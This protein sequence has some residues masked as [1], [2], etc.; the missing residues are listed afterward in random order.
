MLK[1]ICVLDIA[2]LLKYKFDT[3]F[4][5]TNKLHVSVSVLL[6]SIFNNSKKVLYLE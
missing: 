6:K 5:K 3:I 4:H 1:G 2:H